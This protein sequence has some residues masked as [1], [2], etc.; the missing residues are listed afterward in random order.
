MIPF[1]ADQNFNARII[2]GLH[3]RVE[4]ILAPLQKPA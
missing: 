2:R 1:L 3:R 4:G